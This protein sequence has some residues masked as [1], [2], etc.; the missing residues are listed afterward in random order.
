MPPVEQGSDC[1][2]GK[3]L[4]VYRCDNDVMVSVIHRPEDQ[5]L[6]HWTGS[7]L[8]RAELLTSG[9]GAR[10]AGEQLVLWERGPEARVVATAWESRCDKL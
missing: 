1:N 2:L 6:L 10:W 8:E 5:A 3:V 9:G 4:A 7:S